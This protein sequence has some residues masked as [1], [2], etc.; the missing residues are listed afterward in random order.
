[1]R[2][3]PA[4]T[5]TR[6]CPARAEGPG[7][8]RWGQFTEGDLSAETRA[9]SSYLQVEIG[10]AAIMFLLWLLTRV[11]ALIKAVITVVNTECVQH[12]VPITDRQ[13]ARRPDS[14]PRE[15]NLVDAALRRARSGRCRLQ[16]DLIGLALRVVLVE[17][18]RQREG[19]DR[20]GRATAWLVVT[21]LDRNLQDLVGLCLDLCPSAAGAAAARRRALSITISWIESGTSSERSFAANCGS[22]GTGGFRTVTR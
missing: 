21:T 14:P 11:G 16:H 22:P 3:T 7:K 9:C 5:L 10:K 17:L 8:S 15:S 6:S 20:L 2:S 13:T 4:R 12:H 18:R 19:P 1:M